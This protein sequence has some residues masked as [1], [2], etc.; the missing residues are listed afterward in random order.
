MNSVG[1]NA[2]GIKEIRILRGKGSIDHLLRI[3]IIDKNDKIS[4]M[5]LFGMRDNETRKDITIP[6]K[7]TNDIQVTTHEISFLGDVIEEEE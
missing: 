1:I 6:V 3:V 4:D 2:H 5:N 7:I